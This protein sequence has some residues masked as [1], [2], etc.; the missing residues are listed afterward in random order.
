MPAAK[1]AELG[2]GPA[3]CVVTVKGPLAPGAG[4]P[5]GAVCLNAGAAVRLSELAGLPFA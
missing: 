4:H 2:L 1:Q 5:P 3:Y